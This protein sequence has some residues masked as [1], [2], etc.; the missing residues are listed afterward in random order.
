MSA[1]EN[2]CLVYGVQSRSVDDEFYL[3]PNRPWRKVYQYTNWYNHERSHLNKGMNGLTPQAKY[4][5]L[6]NKSV[7]LEG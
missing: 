6:I 7:T 5:S 4:L 3:N 2:V 1:N